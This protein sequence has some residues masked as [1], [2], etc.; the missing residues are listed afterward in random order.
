MRGDGDAVVAP[1]RSAHLETI[2]EGE[3]QRSLVLLAVVD[4]L[5]CGRLLYILP[6][7]ASHGPAT[8]DGRL[9]DRARLHFRSGPTRRDGAG[10]IERP[11]HR[12]CLAPLSMGRP[13]RA[14]AGLRNSRRGSLIPIT[15]CSEAA[16]RKLPEFSEQGRFVATKGVVYSSPIANTP[17]SPR[18]LVFGR[19]AT[20][21]RRPSVARL[22]L[23]ISVSCATRRTHRSS[24]VIASKA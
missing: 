18:S 14:K 23:S 7:V 9:D 2:S 19:V 21:S 12:L 4:A 5:G 10:R 11:C 16:F 6:I 24:P 17:Y 1:P 15:L 22:S 13:S 20:K 3:Q 8:S